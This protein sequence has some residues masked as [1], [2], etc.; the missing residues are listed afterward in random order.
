MQT[1]ICINLF[2]VRNGFTLLVICVAPT[3]L[4]S[5]N[6]GVLITVSWIMRWWP[7]ST[8]DSWRLG[9]CVGCTCTSEGSCLSDSRISKVGSAYCAYIWQGF[10]IGHM[11]T[12]CAYYFAYFAYCAYRFCTMG[13]TVKRYIS[14]YIICHIIQ[15]ILHID[16]F[17]IS[18]ILFCI[19]YIFVVI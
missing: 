8:L 5:F 10:H 2:E 6:F 9:I 4:F 17:D 3:P 7:L 16:I 13:K 1:S 12:Y 15:H 14:C 19:F 11:M 18:C